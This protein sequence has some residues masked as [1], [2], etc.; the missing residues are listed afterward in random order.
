MTSA[1]HAVDP[2]DL[3][4]YLDGE[5]SPERAAA[6]QAHLATCAA[7]Q[8]VSNDLRGVSRDMSAWRVGETP[9]TL[10]APEAPVVGISTATPFRPPR[11]WW[12]SRPAIAIELGG[13]AALVVF[14][15]V[16]GRGFHKPNIEGRPVSVSSESARV[17][18]GE[19]VVAGAPRSSPSPARAASVERESVQSRRGP[20]IVRTATL[21]IVT[22]DFDAVRAAVDRILSQMGGFVG[23][24]NV[25]G[26]LGTPRSLR[27]T[28]RVPAPRLDAT[29]AELKN[30]GQVVGESQVG[31]DVTEQVIDLEARLANN[32]NTEKR[33]TELLRKRTGDLA[34]V[35]AAEREIARVREEIERLDAQRK[36]LEQRV[37]YATLTL[38]LSEERKAEL[39]LGPASVSSR[40]RNAL[41]DGLR[42]AADSLIEIALFAIRVGPFLLLW[43][44]LLALPA[45]VV[46]RRLRRANT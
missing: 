38:E 11:R 35:L 8:Q 45:R 42:S 20:M 9:T 19:G 17:V 12:A 1:E 18:L 3:M 37:S 23:Q 21:Q 14:G 5:L 31:D 22:N 29:L 2:E 43:A 34:D 39:D 27:A 16:L 24:M 44:A 4:A 13:V 46:L 10:R 40:F 36:N 7:C 28:L 25:T 6:V 15:L 32:R 41:V 33:L 26:S 30:L